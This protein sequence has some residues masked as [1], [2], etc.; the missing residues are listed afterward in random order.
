AEA[1]SK[2]PHTVHLTQSPNETTAQCQW[3]IPRA[4]DF[5][6]WGDGRAWDGSHCIRQPLLYPLF[7]GRS[8]IQLLAMMLGEMD[9]DGEQLVRAAVTSDDAAWRASV[10]AGFVP[11]SAFAAASVGAPNAPS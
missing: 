3:R 10:Q 1:L 7:E 2:V 5:E 6:A 4:H 8:E 9:P 11:R